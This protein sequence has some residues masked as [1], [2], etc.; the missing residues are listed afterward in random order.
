M[1][2]RRNIHNV[3]GR[4]L[5]SGRRHIEGYLRSAP[6]TLRRHQRD[7]KLTGGISASRRRVEASGPPGGSKFAAVKRRGGD[8]EQPSKRPDTFGVSGSS[9]APR[10]SDWRFY[11][12]RSIINVECE[13]DGTA[14]ATVF[15]LLTGT[16]TF[17]TDHCLAGLR[18]P[19]LVP[20]LPYRR[21]SMKTMQ[22]CRF[23]LIVHLN[24]LCHRD[25]PCDGYVR[26]VDDHRAC[27]I[28]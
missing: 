24:H 8:V 3:W 19:L 21:V 25:M 11:E 10:D 1:G 2:T 12:Q 18:G 17:A 27:G 13:E 6:E 7:V 20:H 22:L 5:V 26:D 9:L 23:G 4:S 15:L 28:S 14:Q 16:D